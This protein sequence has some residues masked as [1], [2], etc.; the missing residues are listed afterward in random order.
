[1][2][3]KPQSERVKKILVKQ[4]HHV[5]DNIR[6][7]ARNY[8]ESDMKKHGVKRTTCNPQFLGYECKEDGKL[9]TN[10][11]GGFGVVSDWPHLCHMVTE[12]GVT[13][14]WENE[15]EADVMK[16]GA[17]QINYLCDTTN[18]IRTFSEKTLDH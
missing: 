16:C 18:Q 17:A 13:L 7:V 15:Y 10:V 4:R 3:K 1:M 11:K 2:H 9:K 12:V 5:D 8:L 6:Y 14:K